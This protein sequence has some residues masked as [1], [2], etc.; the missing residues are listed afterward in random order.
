MASRP[1]SIHAASYRTKAQYERSRLSAAERGYGS[2][3]RK[4]REQK[5]KTPCCNPDCGAPWQPGHHLDHIKPR[6]QGGLDHPSNLQWLCHRCHSSKTAK[7]DGR[8]SR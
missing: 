8:W 4:L 6:A 1:P 5:P 7:V 2:D 3:W